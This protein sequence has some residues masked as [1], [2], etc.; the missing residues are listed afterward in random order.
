M[1]QIQ[2]EQERLGREAEERSKE[3][4]KREQD[5]IARKSAQERLEQLKSTALGAKVF[6]EMSEAVGTVINNVTFTVM[7]LHGNGMLVIHRAWFHM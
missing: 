3:R 2:A 4:I 6:A 7:D 5:E 1:K